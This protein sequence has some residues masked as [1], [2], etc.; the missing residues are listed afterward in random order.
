M[1]PLCNGC[2]PQMVVFAV[3]VFVTL[4]SYAVGCSRSTNSVSTSFVHEARRQTEHGSHTLCNQSFS[5]L[6]LKLTNF[7]FFIPDWAEALEHENSTYGWTTSCCVQG[8]AIRQMSSLKCLRQIKRTTENLLLGLE[9][10]F[11]GFSDL[12]CSLVFW[13]RKSTIMTLRYI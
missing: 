2:R 8:H 3:A 11:T 4:S 6:V 1:E 13:S 7:F 5:F 9:Q 10:T 12:T